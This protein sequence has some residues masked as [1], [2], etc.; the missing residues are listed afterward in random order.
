MTSDNLYGKLNSENIA[1]ENQVCRQIVKEISQFGINERQR[2]FIIYSLS[3]ELEDLTCMKT[4]T[5]A[6]KSS[7]N[8]NVFLS[9]G[10][11]DGQI[12]F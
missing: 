1:E 12:G 11:D 3:L 5:S 10:D 2:L 7:E 8:K 9:K 4:I 6:I